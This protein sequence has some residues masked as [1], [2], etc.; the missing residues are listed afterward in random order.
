EHAGEDGG[1]D[2]AAGEHEADPPAG[3]RGAIAEDGG[4]ARGGGAF[5]DVVRVGEAGAKRGFGFV[6]GHAHDAFHAVEDVFEGGGVGGRAREAV[7]DA[8]GAGVR[9]Q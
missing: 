4:E 6:V 9:H 7:G 5:D 8:R 2:V 3:N 1:V